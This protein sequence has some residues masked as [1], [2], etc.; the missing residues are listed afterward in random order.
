MN[1]RKV[2]SMRSKLGR[3]AKGCASYKEGGGCS[4]QRCG[5]CVVQIKTDSAIGNVCPYF[6]THVLPAD[7]K[8]QSEYLAYFPQDERK[9]EGDSK[10][11]ECLRCGG[12]YEKGS[13]AAKYCADCRALNERDKARARKQKERRLTSRN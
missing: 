6:M 10:R 12:E 9:Q 13:N 3:Q 5:L 7:S 1:R 4:V 8:L 11:A 2:D